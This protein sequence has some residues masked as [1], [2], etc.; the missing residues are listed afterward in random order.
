[1]KRETKFKLIAILVILL[2]IGSGFVVLFY[3]HT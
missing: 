3:G 2:M 1:M